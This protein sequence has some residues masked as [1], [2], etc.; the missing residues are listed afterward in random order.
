[1][2]QAVAKL[3]LRLGG[4]SPEYDLALPLRA[5]FIA[6]PHTSN[7]DAFWALTYKVAIRLDVHWFAKNSLFWFPL[8]ALLRSLG[9][10]PLDRKRAGSAVD[11]AVSMFRDNEQY[12]FGLAPEGTRSRADHW[13]TGFYRIALAADVPVLLGFIDYG[14]KRIGIGPML[15]LSGDPEKDLGFCREF[16]AGIEGR[17][18]DK[19]SPIA[20]PERRNKKGRDKVPARS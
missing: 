15:K 4:W 7:W 6:A 19:V 12:H 16:Y 18:P 1:M 3:I 5:V 11:Q 14:R 2:L 8:G 17:W 13:K 9:G 20:F 10:V